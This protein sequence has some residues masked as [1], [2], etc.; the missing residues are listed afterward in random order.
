MEF[1][2]QHYIVFAV[3]GAL[4]AWW[5]IFLPSLHLLCAETEGDHP[6]LRSQFL[7]GVIWVALAILVVPILVMPLLNEKSRISFIISLTQGFL[8]RS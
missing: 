7:S 8:R 2:I 5:S 3:S 1:W 6:V 4:V